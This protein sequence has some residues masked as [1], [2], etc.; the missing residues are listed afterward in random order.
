MIQPTPRHCR[1]VAVWG[2]R[3]DYNGL[4]DADARHNGVQF[5]LERRL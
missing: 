1:G 2:L 5:S 4:H 3:V